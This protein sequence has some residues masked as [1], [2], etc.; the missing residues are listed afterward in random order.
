MT[1]VS[2]LEINKVAIVHNLAFFKSK[3]N[4]NTKILV[5]VKAFSYGS[6]SILVA[7]ILQKSNVDYLAVAYV[8]EGVCLRNNGITLPILVLHPQINNLS[9]LVKYDLEPNIYSGK[10]L[11]EFISISKKEKLNNYPIHLKFNTGLNRLG[12]LPNDVE[13]V[14]AKIKNVSEIKIESVFSHLAAS[15]DLSEID[16][17]KQQINCFI[18][19]K[20]KIITLLNYKPTF[21]LLNTS[22]I[23][24]YTE[25][26]F[27]MVRLGIGLYGFANDKK[28]TKEL[29]NV[30][31]LKSVISQI[32]NI[33]KGISIGYNRSFIAKN[34]IK[35]ATIPIGHADGISRKFGNGNAYVLINNK[36]AFIIGNVCMD[37]I[38]VDVTNIDCTEGDEVIIF[39]SQNRIKEMSSKLHTIPYEFLT[40]IS[41]R[42]RRK[43]T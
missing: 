39:N 18:E 1:N 38:M 32:H 35:S 21:H 24:N 34:N 36:K 37:M 2:V 31:S 11:T 7:E 14:L 5:V 41:Q 23:V 13:T 26:Q 43:I 42:V 29:E 19:I 20:N 16:F 15:E 6:D 28:T 4:K 8:E 40:M 3:L 25:F 9:L 33:K 27:N 12:F 10:I 22:G 30:L 17:T